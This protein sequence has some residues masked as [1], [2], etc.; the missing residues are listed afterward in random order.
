MAATFEADG[1]GTLLVETFATE[2]LVPALMA[3][4]W[5]IGSYRG[6]SKG[7]LDSFERLAEREASGGISDRGT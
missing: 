3:R 6:S 5:A 4:L 7:E 2:G 1:D